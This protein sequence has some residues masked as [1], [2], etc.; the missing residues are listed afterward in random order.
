MRSEIMQLLRD[1]Y[2]EQREKNTREEYRRRAE[3]EERI[4]GLGELLQER[5]ELIY[6]SVRGIL[7]GAKA[8]NL[9]ERMEKLN[10]RIAAMLTAGG[11]PATWLDPVYRCP[12]CRDT[13]YTG[14]TV[15]EMCA[16]MRAAYHSEVMRQLGL[17]DDAGV[18]FERFDESIIPEKKLEDW[19]ITQ[20][21][22]S[23]RIRDQ[24][25]QW[26]QA[27]PDAQR[28]VLMYGESGLGKTY[29]MRCMAR[30]LTEGGHEVLLISAYQ[31]M[32]AARK[33]VFGGEADEL[34]ACME[35]ECLLLDDLGSEPM[36]P[37]ITVEQLYSLI[38][39]R[40]RA[41]RAT[42]VSTNLNPEQLRNRYGERI[43]SRLT[44]RSNA[45]ILAFR[46]DD[47]RR[48]DGERRATV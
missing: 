20:R 22:L 19:G 12:I 37:N 30:A 3:A 28:I 38:N 39:E 24:A 1:T 17:G 10:G 11:Y 7:T 18:S 34:I 48:V 29:L 16:C 45:L 47:L 4:H 26:T 40:G 9:P 13:G 14:D 23:V 5:Q 8:E 21:A 6:S 42:V 36:I 15:R 27:W 2:A 25:R 41:G 44:D 35:T 46:G 31:L 43:V 33:A 32:D